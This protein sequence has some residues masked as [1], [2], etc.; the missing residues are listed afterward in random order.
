MLA[1][2]ARGGPRPARPRAP[3]SWSRSPPSNDVHTVATL[4]RSGATGFLAKGHLGTTFADDLVRCTQGQ[5]MI[6]VPHGPRCS[7]PSGR[8]SLDGRTA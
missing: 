3:Q 6:A 2:G 4:F 5:V 7:E 1:G 8:V